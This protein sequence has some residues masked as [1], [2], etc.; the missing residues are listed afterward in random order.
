MDPEEAVGDQ[1]SDWVRF[2][3]ILLSGGVAV[4]FGIAMTILFII[5][6][7]SVYL[8]VEIVGVI[9]FLVF[10]YNGDDISRN[11]P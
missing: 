8:V 3:G 7:S 5:I 10:I 2:S 1:A 4:L 9:A 11:Y 6:M